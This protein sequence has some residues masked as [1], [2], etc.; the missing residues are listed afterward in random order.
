MI[1]YNCSL[2]I[3]VKRMVW[4]I[5]LV[6]LIFLILYLYRQNYLHKIRSYQID[7]GHLDQS[8]KGKKIIFL[9]DTHF[10][11]KTSLTFIDRI[12][13]DIEKQKPDLILFGGDI[14]HRLENDRVLEHTKDF[15]FQL[16]KIAPSYL[17]YGNH[18]LATNRLNEI[19]SMLDLAGAKL[20]DNE[21]VWINFDQSENGFW[22]MGIHDLS[23]R[24]RT[25]ENPLEKVNFPRKP[26]N[27]AK[28]L[29]AH[30]PE[31]IENYLRDDS[32]RPNLILSGHTHGGQAILPILGGL[33]AP[34]QG[35]LPK[36]DFGMFTSKKHPNSR[37][38][39]TRGIGNSRFPFRI[40]NRPEIV[41]IE[42][43]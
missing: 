29:V 5:L 2:I 40:N 11:E 16:N 23:N 1:Y 12:L 25:R 36:Y 31:F 26:E 9:S 10:R 42:F 35:F 7:S 21:A 6:G 15:F 17:I 8:L 33:F 30:H 13:I 18:D 38:I 37:M 3:E 24:I 20:L 22:L 19:K 28:I 14:V 39:V 32:R 43:S 41:V 34:G 4:K 27:E